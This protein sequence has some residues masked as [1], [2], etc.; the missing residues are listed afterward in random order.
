M[1]I[2]ARLIKLIKYSE[3]IDDRIQLQNKFDIVV[4]N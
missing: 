1:Y 4:R 3:I 2:Y